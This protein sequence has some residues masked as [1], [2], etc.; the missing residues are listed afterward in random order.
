LS[1]TQAGALGLPGDAQR[2]A[3]EA[4]A[5]THALRMPR[6]TL[7]YRRSDNGEPL[8]VSPLIERMALALQR[9]GRSLPR[10][11][12][13]RV[14]LAVGSDPSHR[15]A[16]AA[17]DRLPMRLSAAACT[18]LRACPYQFF[19][20]YVLGAREAEEIESELEKRDYGTWLH[21][22]LH[23]FHKERAAPASHEAELARL[24]AVAEEQRLARGLSEEEF[25]PFGAS[26][27][28]LA[29][30]Y[31]RWVHER[32]AQG[33]SWSWGEREHR[34]E[35]P[36]SRG[37]ELYGIVDRADRVGGAM[38]LI[39]YKTGSVDDLKKQVRDRLED[40]QLAVYAALVGP[41]ADAPLQAMYL[42]LDSRKGIEEVTH[43]DVE[44]TAAELLRGL[45]NDLAQLRGGAGMPALGEGIV[46]ERCDARGLCRRDHWPEEERA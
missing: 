7:M 19:A 34:L 5:F 3:Q 40:T 39:D 17:P 6:I 21:A 12:D 25:L 2:R 27:D 33:A 30:N 9:Q 23:E 15:P 38:Q 36:D 46:C 11:V 28:E 16:P 18:S 26:F 24:H 32:D 29:P 43:P 45:S 31:I 44:K 22:V 42:A 14:R 41:T 8:S 10:W 20:R 35:L 4:A 1:D 13:P 37:E